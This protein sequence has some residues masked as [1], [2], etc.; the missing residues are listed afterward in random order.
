MKRFPRIM[1]LSAF[2]LSFRLAGCIAPRPYHRTAGDSPATASR[3]PSPQY[4]QPS[5]DALFV[6]AAP[7]ANI[8]FR[9][10]NGA[11]GHL[12]YIETTPA[13]CAFLD[14]DNDGF[15]DVLLIQSGPSRP[16][17]PGETRPFCTLYHN[18]GD[19]TFTDV[20]TGSGLDKDLGYAQGV[21]IGD[22]DNDG[23][24]D[25]FITGYPRNFLFHND[26]GTGKFTDV[27]HAMGLDRPH[28]TG[29]ATSAA[30]G[31]YD[32]DGK[33][34]LYVCYYSVW[35][36]SEDK[37]CKSAQGD[38]D[39]CT[40]ELYA[41]EI[42][43]LWHNE[44]NRFTETTHRAGIDRLAGRGLAACF[45][46]FNDDGRQD[47]FVANDLNPNRLWRNNGDGTFTDVALSAGV[48]YG[49]GGQLMSGMGI[50]LADYDQSG[51]ESLFVTNFTDKPNMLYK[52]LGNGIF[53]DVSYESGVAL[54]HMKFLSF[55]CE[56]LDY[57]ADGWP[58]LITANGH[59][60]LHAGS[61]LEGVTYAER[62]QLLHN[63]GKGVFQEITDPGL[64]G[65]LSVPTVAR[66][67][68]TGDYD[69]DGRID[70]LVNNQ[71]GPA[72][73]FHNLDRSANHWVS[74]KTVGSKS[75]RDGYG[76]IITLTA[77]SVRRMASVH[78]GTSYLSHSDRRV[79]FGL[80][81]AERI[82]SVE[83]RW[84]SGTKDI[85]TNVA[86]N[87]SYVVTEG[88]GITGSLPVLK[89]KN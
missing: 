79:Y 30:F 54:P 15:I 69:N 10:S 65:D 71:N 80:G 14:Y 58:D 53:R 39:Y 85:L 5:P 42:D 16:L 11:D 89:S 31:D 76:A 70:V 74:F 61:P 62:K 41:P 82:E 1:I 21:A 23:C 36:R 87:K 72:Q 37:P 18:N 57:D 2:L 6:D 26:H 4:T 68:A 32:N 40:P 28:S 22:Y 33:L 67:L 45:L 44:G 52:N 59:V 78:N 35:T 66:G 63:S 86:V 64:L 83:I 75:N 84:P 19:G 51:R 88:R 47:V 49:D 24:E 73:L 60:Q 50:G 43:Q 55:G 9:H 56:F 29:Y 12:R 48:A 7:Q 20:T 77:G 34:D 27:S 13:G 46:D 8:H 17:L 25:L 3:T 81:K 38:P